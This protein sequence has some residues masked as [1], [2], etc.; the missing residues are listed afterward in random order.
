MASGALKTSPG[1]LLQLMP[2][3]KFL[4]DS[5]RHADGS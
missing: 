4:H 2:N 3:W 5:G 1:V